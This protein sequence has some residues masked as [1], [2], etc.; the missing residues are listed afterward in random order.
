MARGGERQGSDSHTPGT[1]WDPCPWKQGATRAAAAEPGR[2]EMDGAVVARGVCSPRQRDAAWGRVGATVLG[3]PNR[4][5]PPRQHRRD[6]IPLS[7][8]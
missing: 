3:S 8:G 1:G 2:A 7:E 4:L 5:C 6:P